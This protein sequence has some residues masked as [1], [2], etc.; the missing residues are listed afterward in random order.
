MKAEALKIRRESL[1]VSQKKLSK[2][3]GV[4][5]FKISDFECD[6]GGLNSK[7]IKVI[8]AYLSKKEGGQK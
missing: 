4:S 5:R 1:G 8:E 7:E 3:T 6:Y 2:E